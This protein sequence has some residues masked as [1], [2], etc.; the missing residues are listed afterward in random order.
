MPESI[1]KGF[2]LVLGVDVAR[3]GLDATVF[4]LR[5]GLRVLEFQVYRG[6]NNME[7]ADKVCSLIDRR[8]IDATF[9]DAGAGSGVIDRVRQLGF[10]VTEVPFAGA[11]RLAR[12]ANKRAEMFWD[13]AEWI[14]GHG[15]IPHNAELV[16]ELAAFSYCFKRDRIQVVDKDEIKASLGRSPD[17][18]DALALTFAS[19][20]QPRITDWKQLLLPRS[21][22]HRRSTDYDVGRND[23]FRNFRKAASED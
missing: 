1:T 4:C 20:V 3:F 18:A 11:P 10:N 13:L 23:P 7:V 22:L 9:C 21:Q 5:Q 6:L 8:G 19:P 14:R 12:F 2:A 17:Q 15:S 16:D